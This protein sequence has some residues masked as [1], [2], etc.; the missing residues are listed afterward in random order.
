VGRVPAVVVR[1]ATVVAAIAAVIA[2]IIGIGI[3]FRIL[4]ANP[5]NAIVSFFEGLA[6]F[7][8]GPF[9]GMFSPRNPKVAV[10][11]NW[12]IAL[13]VYLVVGRVIANLLRRAGPAEP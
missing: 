12:G 1:V 4:G 13:L 8:V 10:A 6:R 2:A 5:Q 7:F 11:V 9:D 3:L